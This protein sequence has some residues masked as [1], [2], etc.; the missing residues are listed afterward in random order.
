MA[1][2]VTPTVELD[3]E[4]EETQ[5]LICGSVTLDSSYPTGGYGFDPSGVSAITHLVAAGGPVSLKWDRANQKLMA[6]V[7]NGASPALLN[8]APN[9]TNLSTVTNVPFMAIASS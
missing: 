7:S 1:A 9:T 6:F 2:T 4:I 5:H 3:I 8:E